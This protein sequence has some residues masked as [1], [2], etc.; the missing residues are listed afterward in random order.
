MNNK[1]RNIFK[2]AGIATTGLFLW[3]FLPKKI[4]KI[5]AEKSNTD[6]PI[7]SIHPDAVSRNRSK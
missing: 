2:F 1:R 5:V 4:A 6:K 7:V 3:S